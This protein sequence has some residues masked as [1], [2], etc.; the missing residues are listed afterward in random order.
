MTATDDS[1]TPAGPPDTS[2]AAGFWFV[3]HTKPRQEILAREH[4]LRQAF[5]VYLPMFKVFKA[6]RRPGAAGQAAASR[7]GSPSAQALT[8]H[9]PMFPRYLFLRPSRPTQSLSAVRSTQ[10]VSRLVMFGNQPAC[11]A[12]ALVEGIRAAETARDEADFAQISPYRP[13]MPVRLQDPALGGLQALVQA[14]SHDRVTLL[15]EILGRPQLV[16]VDFERITPL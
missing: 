7:L 6:P 1:E 16:S 14:V 5:E 9:E 3:V 8:S 11:I 4:L 12:Q 10:G 15:L 2:P 13:G